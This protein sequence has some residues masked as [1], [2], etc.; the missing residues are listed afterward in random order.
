[1]A[2]VVVEP[3]FALQTYLAVGKDVVMVG[4]GD[5]EFQIQLLQ[6]SLGIMK[7]GTQH[8]FSIT[9]VFE[10]AVRTDNWFILPSL[11]LSL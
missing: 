5:P 6:R 10:K 4:L 9:A 2:F 11:T 8:L 7:A 3:M 1:M